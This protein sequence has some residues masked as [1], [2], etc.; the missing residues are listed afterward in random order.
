MAILRDLP[1]SLRHELFQRELANG[2]Q[3]LIARL[4]ARLLE[5]AHQAL[6]HQRADALRHVVAVVDTGNQRGCRQREAADEHAELAELSA[7]LGREQ[8]VAPG[9][10]RAQG[11]MARWL[12]AQPTGQHR[13][14]LLVEASGQ[15]PGR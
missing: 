5:S 11:L 2:L 10:R 3:Q 15:R 7:L 4:T 14:R 13:Q 1:F 6:G 12:V 8:R 9:D